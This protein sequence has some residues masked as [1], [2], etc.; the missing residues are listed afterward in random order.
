MIY[1]LNQIIA[2][3]EIILIIMVVGILIAMIFSIALF[4]VW[5]DFVREMN[6]SKR[7]PMSDHM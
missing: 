6:R 3:E 1:Q 4:L 5:I 2:F 7:D